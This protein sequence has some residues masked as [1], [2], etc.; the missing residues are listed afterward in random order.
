MCATSNAWPDMAP[1]KEFRW[2]TKIPRIRHQ[3]ISFWEPATT[4]RSTE[5]THLVLEPLVNQLG[6]KPSSLDLYVATKRNGLVHDVLHADLE[7]RVWTVLLA[8]RLGTSKCRQ[9]TISK[10]SMQSVRNSYVAIQLDGV[11]LDSH[12]ARRRN[13][14]TGRES[15]YVHGWRDSFITYAQLRQIDRQD[16]WLPKRRIEW[17]SF[18]RNRFR[19]E[20]Q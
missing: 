12:G 7:C 4:L 13:S 5:K 10:M 14:A 1:W 18:E 19:R 3:Y 9:W 20:Q 2:K 16:C 17:S 11:R 8:R 6:K 15:K